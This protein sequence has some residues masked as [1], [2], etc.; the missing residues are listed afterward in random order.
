MLMAAQTTTIAAARSMPVG[1][2]VTVAGIVI[3]GS[4]LGKIRYLQDGTAGLA[5]YPGS[6]S[7]PGF[8]AA[9]SLGDSILVSGTLVSYH[10]LLEITPITSYTV[11]AQNLPQPTPKVLT[12]SDISEQYEG[13]LV[14][15][16]CVVF[17]DGGGNFSTGTYE[18]MDADG[19]TGKVY[20]SSTHPLQGENIPGTPVFLTTILSEYDDY[21]LL[22][23]TTDDFSGTLCFYFEQFPEQS[24]ITT[25]GFDVSWST[26]LTG[27]AKIHY[28]TTPALGTT[29]IVPGT[30][31]A[32]TFSLTGL[33]P[34]TVYWVQ[35]ETV[36]NGNILRSPPT[37]FAT[38]SLSSGQI[39]VFFN[40]SINPDYAN[41]FTP[42]GVSNAAVVAETIARINAAQQT[43]DVAMYNN[44]RSDI[45]NAIKDAYARG[46]R[47]RYVAALDASSTALNPPPAFPVLYGNS[48][49]IM[50]DK[51]LVIDADLP[52]KAWV[53]SG[54]LNWTNQNINTDFNN[55]LFIQDQSL[56]RA[57]RVEF[58]EMWGSETALPN[59]QNSRFGSNKRDN[60][61]HHF[62]IGGRRVDSWFSPSDRTTDRIVETIYG[63][64]EEIRF[65]AFSFT[66]NEIGDALVDAFSN[67]VSV[68]GMIENI[69]DP[70]AEINYL[71]SAGIDCRP[72][73]TTGELH[74]KYGVFD[75]SGA[76]PV[77]LTGSHNWTFAAET[78]N[79][80]N[81]L[82]I[83]DQRLASLYRAEWQQ[84]WQE[85]SLSAS[86]PNNSAVHIFPNPAADQVDVQW[87]G[88]ASAISIKNLLGQTVYTRQLESETSGS[89]LKI[90][91]LTPGPYIILL[92]TQH[93][94]TAIPFQK[95]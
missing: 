1:S 20:I 36:H 8:E 57:Y 30:A 59:E 55:T 71:V 74:H 15:F 49:A 3:N 65:A 47:V 90:S 62:I 21:Q 51:V 89:T 44:N 61:P 32:G 27:A 48:E 73:P 16:E 91:F 6:G 39:K 9:V 80:E 67:Q 5:A 95:I 54:S 29:Q 86:A 53:M 64:S 87:T 38:Q 35:V 66:K 22:P 42:D 24:A 41:G 19:Q 46:V 28:G 70:G 69:S 7:A 18:V 56:A 94:F 26:N 77:V 14:G 85:N 78:V 75:A 11:L 17:S 12:L 45:T 79:D 52:D 23:R 84:R 10:G 92:Q 72:H 58:E 76:D 13:Q 40:H 31:S 81:T 33:Q 50:H 83:H 43:L 63:A 82:I 4:E 34:G 2:T 60:T 93:E 68:S 37:P 88:S 25:T